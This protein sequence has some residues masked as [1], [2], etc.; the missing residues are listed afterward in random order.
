MP[1][2][3]LKGHLPAGAAAAGAAAGAAVPSLLLLRLSVKAAPTGTF[4]AAAGGAAVLL[5]RGV[6]GS[7]TLPLL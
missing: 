6:T 4:G 5:L 1:S 2:A 3:P 7:T